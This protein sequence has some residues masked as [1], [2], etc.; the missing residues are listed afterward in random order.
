[1]VLARFKEA[2]E[3]CAQYKSKNEEVKRHF[4]DYAIVQSTNL[5]KGHQEIRDNLQRISQLESLVMDK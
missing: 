3:M 4:N 5:V 2:D 1:M